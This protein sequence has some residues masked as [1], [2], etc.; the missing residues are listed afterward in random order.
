MLKSTLKTLVRARN[1][2]K[3]STTFVYNAEASQFRELP[4]KIDEIRK[5]LASNDDFIQEL[6]GDINIDDEGEESEEERSHDTFQ[7]Q[8]N[9]INLQTEI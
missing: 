9:L 2:N 4:D 3:G 5:A 8:S 7:N 1:S 6:I